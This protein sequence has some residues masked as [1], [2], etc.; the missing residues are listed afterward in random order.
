MLELE[1]M[2][3][4]RQEAIQRQVEK[5][6]LIRQVDNRQLKNRKQVSAELLLRRVVSLIS[7]SSFRFG[8]WLESRMGESAV[9]TPVRTAK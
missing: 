1:I 4:A 8:T 3:R 9:S 7:R 5:R 2:A 6:Q